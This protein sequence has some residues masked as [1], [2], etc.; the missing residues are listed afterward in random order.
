MMKMMMT[1]RLGPAR[2]GTITRQARR[3][4]R[5]RDNGGA[6]DAGSDSHSGTLLQENIFKQE[7]RTQ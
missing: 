1:A 7:K 4:G 6:K 3:T 5:I 2:Y